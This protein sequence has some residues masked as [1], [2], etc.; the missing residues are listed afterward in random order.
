MYPSTIPHHPE[1]ELYVPFPIHSSFSSDYWQCP[2]RQEKNALA[3]LIY[4]SQFTI[5]FI[6]ITT[7]VSSNLD[8]QKIFVIVCEA[9]LVV[10]M[11]SVS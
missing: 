9:D 4:P 6:D 7:F 3:M 2:V 11:L 5:P 1:R 10:L 8:I